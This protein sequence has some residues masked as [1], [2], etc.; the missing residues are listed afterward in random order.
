LHRLP[1]R[2]PKQNQLIGQRHLELELSSDKQLIV[3][4]RCDP[5]TNP[6]DGRSLSFSTP[7]SRGGDYVDID[8]PSCAYPY[9]YISAPEPDCEGLTEGGCQLDVGAGET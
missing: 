2:S 6:V 5:G 3:L 9:A 1:S 7:I 8:E 4:R